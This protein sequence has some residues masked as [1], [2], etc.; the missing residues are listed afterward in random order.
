VQQISIADRRTSMIRKL[1]LFDSLDL[2][3]GLLPGHSS[4]VLT[5]AKKANKQLTELEGAMPVAVQRVLLPRCR[6]AVAALTEMRDGFWI[7]DSRTTKGVVVPTA[8][9][10][11]RVVSY[12]DAVGMVLR[13]IRNGHHG[14]VSDRFHNDIGD[15]AMLILHDGRIPDALPD[16]AFFHLVRLIAFADLLDPGRLHHRRPKP[17]V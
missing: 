11:T 16:L 14:F 8:S 6:A 4:Q 9:D 10:K 3:E 7:P 1:L 2:I 17:D 12:D 15:R 13:M 5:S